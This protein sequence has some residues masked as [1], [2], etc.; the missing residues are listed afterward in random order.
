MNYFQKELG[1]GDKSLDSNSLIN[2]SYSMSK[3]SLNNTM[4]N[5]G[6]NTSR[7]N[8]VS[9]INSLL[10]TSNNPHIKLDDESLDYSMSNNYS[11]DIGNSNNKKFNQN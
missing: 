6:L 10:N 5:G 3:L 2:D 11:L 9:G 7:Q 1:L 4:S 8:G